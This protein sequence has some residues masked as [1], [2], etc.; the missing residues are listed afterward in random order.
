VVITTPEPLSA[1]CGAFS[2]HRSR[3]DEVVVRLPRGR[4]KPFWAGGTGLGRENGGFGL[5]PPAKTFTVVVVIDAMTGK[6]VGG[7]IW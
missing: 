1:M 3:P 7:I 2:S 5:R 6:V 4:L